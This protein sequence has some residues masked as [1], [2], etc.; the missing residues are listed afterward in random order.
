MNTEL[1]ASIE[2]LYTAFS[3]V[4]K[5]LIIEGCP[6]CIERKGVDV[7]LTTPLRQITPDQLRNYAFSV[8][9]TVGCVE[10]FLYFLPRILEIS[11]SD[12]SWSPNPELVSAKMKTAGFREWQELRKSTIVSYY[13]SVLEIALGPE[14]SGWEIDTWICALGQIFPD[15][16][17][18]LERLQ[19]HPQKVV[20]YY[21]EN[22]DGLVKGRLTNSFWD[23]ESALAYDQV[24]AWFKSEPIRNMINAQYG[25]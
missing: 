1:R 13:N 6:C 7:L 19:D 9:N 25:L 8:F 17:T 10:D 22:S 20:E 24:M 4:P 21:E 3:D 15:I 12:M 23:D 16:S 14:L 18:F 2:K 5:P 11:A